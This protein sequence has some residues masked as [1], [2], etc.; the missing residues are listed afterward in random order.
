MKSVDMEK[1][2]IPGKILRRMGF[3]SENHGLID[4]YIHVEG[5]WDEHL[6]QT[7][8]FIAGA[9][10]GKNFKNLAVLGSGWLLDCPLELLTD[11]SGQVWLYDAI[12]PSQVI[13]KLRKHVNVTP[14]KSDIT[15]GCILNAWQAVQQYRKGNGKTAPEVICNG[16]FK[17][18]PTP[19]YVISLN[20]LSQI[21]V[22]ITG[23]L[24]QFIPY[25]RQEIERINFLLQQAHL[26][27]LPN[28]KS[29]LI[30]DFREVNTSLSGGITETSELLNVSLPDSPKRQSW[31]WQ[32]DPDGSYKSG[33]KTVFQVVA[34]EI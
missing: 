18:D 21:G 11:V 33:R 9:V 26:N 16:I 24:E 6:H 14:V 32:F 29:C 15:G 4:R 34:Q 17:M 31:E 22:M 12:H 19:D 25:S 10:A 5:A 23:Y 27:L 3:L 28:G 8:E 20:L 1:E 13:H 30:T 7:R 2:N